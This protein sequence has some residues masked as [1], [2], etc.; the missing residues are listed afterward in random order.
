MRAVL[1]FHS[2]DARAGALSFHPSLF[3]QLFV[4]IADS[5]F[6]IVDLD[7]L[8]APDAQRGIAITFDDGM[9][10]V[11]TAA[12]P[13][14][15]AYRVPAH[16][17]LCTG[18]LAGNQGN[19]N[20]TLGAERFPMLTWDEVCR[21]HDGGVAIEC[22]T[23]RHP[24]LRK[25]TDEDIEAECATADSLIEQYVGRKPKYFAYPFGYHD[26]R[27]RRCIETRYAAA[28]STR[29]GALSPGDESSCLPRLDAYYLRLPFLMRHFDSPMARSYFL[30]RRAMRLLR[31]TE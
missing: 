4:A 17:F 15:R 25:L 8:L 3:E 24:D 23:H 7:T 2:V 29:L 31:G 21:L 9:Q 18:A 30:L 6:P 12:L 10:S 27:V 5:G 28:F 20:L 11:V 16:V 14:L 22:H 1:T 26:R 13:V 19:T